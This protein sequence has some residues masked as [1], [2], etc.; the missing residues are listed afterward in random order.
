MTTRPVDERATIRI[1]AAFV[2]GSLVMSAV[3]TYFTA[4]ATVDARVTRVETRIESIVQR[5]EQSNGELAHAI[6]MLRDELRV[7]Y[8]RRTP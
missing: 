8:Q 6:D 2:V 1:G 7:Y 4:Q 3:V 5:L